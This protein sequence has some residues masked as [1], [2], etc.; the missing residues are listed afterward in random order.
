MKNYIF[1]EYDI[2]GIVGDDFEIDEVGSLTSA[3]L[4]YFKTLDPA[5][6]TL[7]IG[8][9]GRVHSP[10]I[11]DRVVS[12]VTSHGIDCID[13]GVC[14]TPVFYFSLFNLPA[15]SG[16]M[17][18]A[19]HNPAE[20]NG[21]KLCYNRFPVFGTELQK[22]RELMG[23]KFI[24]HTFQHGK[25]VQR[26]MTHKYCNFLA[27]HFFALKNRSL[28]CAIDCGN[29]TAGV[30]LPE[31]VNAMNWSD[32][33]LL[34][35]E[36]DGT[37]PNHEADPTNVEAMND[38]AATVRAKNYTMG[39][40]FDGDCDRMAPTTNSGELVSGDKLLAL[41]A[42]TISSSHVTLPII[43]DIKTSDAVLSILRSWKLNPLLAP[44]G[45]SRIKSAMVQHRAALAGEL[46]CHFF[47]ADRYFGYDDGI[48]AFLRLLEFIEHNKI[49]LDAALNWFPQSVATPEIRLSCDESRKKY[50]VNDV[51]TYFAARRECD[52]I[53]IDGVRVQKQNGWGLARVSN[54]QPVISLRFEAATVEALNEIKSDFAEA[55]QKHFSPMELYKTMG[56]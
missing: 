28:S 24:A 49:S 30:V 32:V 17:I 3:I 43:C 48:Y 21:F 10:A 26:P 29:G 5:L 7:V 15:T 37:F 36:V 39:V 35:E 47:F 4:A 2:R 56:V 13:I 34:Y 16:I 1:R 45:H 55:L 18:T 23:T 20:Y 52:L 27:G 50:I 46:S 54:T 25:I 11:Y 22:I 33:E 9:D 53:T 19:S 8:R 38:L 41:F 14:P 12:V 31:L 6:S 51:K 44:S 40:G 42:K